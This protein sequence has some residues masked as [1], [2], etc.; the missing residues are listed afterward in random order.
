L[1]AYQKKNRN[2]SGITVA[3]HASTC[4]RLSHGGG[5][6]SHLLRSARA[7][8]ADPRPN[9]PQAGQEWAAVGALIVTALYLALSGAEVATQRS[10]IMIALSLSA[11]CSTGRCCGEE[12]TDLHYARRGW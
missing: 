2:E 12:L 9:G 3:A 4:L 7:A 8:G 5:R 1:A 6:R 11:T 10:L